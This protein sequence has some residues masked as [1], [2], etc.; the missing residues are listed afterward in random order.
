MR[1]HFFLMR[2]VGRIQFLK[3][4]G[5]QSLLFCSL[6]A[7]GPCSTSRGC[8]ITWIAALF[9]YVKSQEH[10]DDAFSLVPLWPTCKRFSAFKD[11]G[12]D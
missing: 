9:F 5:P 6:S 10:C 4:V 1:I 7:G 8:P 12:N 2:V 11:S 3:I